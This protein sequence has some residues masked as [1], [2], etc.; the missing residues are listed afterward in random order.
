MK[1]WLHIAAVAGCVWLAVGRPG[2][3]GDGSF[4]NLYIGNNAQFGTS[5][6]H[7][8]VTIN[9][10][11]G[12]SATPGL[13]LTGDGG[14][15]FGGTFGTGAIPT[16]AVGTYFIWYPGK[17]ACVGGYMTYLSDP[18]SIGNY[19]FAFGNGACAG[20]EGAVAFGRSYGFG[21]YSAAVGA[22]WAGKDYSFATGFSDTEA[23]DSVALCEAHTDGA[24]SFAAIAGMTEGDN[25]AAIGDAVTA[26]SFD[27]CVIGANNAPSLLSANGN[28]Q[29]DP[30][31]ELFVIGN[32]ADYSHPSNALIVYKSGAITMPKRQGDIVMGVYGNGNGD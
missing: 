2:L 22:A 25:S 8:S 32:G 26:T 19:A 28:T 23:I 1:H 18:N 6:T 13:T 5:S 15:T 31:D 12:S 27:S 7:G 3:A 17:A 20:G 14:V 4:D 21:Q 29:W 30:S 10:E 16:T 9:G 11:T 24:F